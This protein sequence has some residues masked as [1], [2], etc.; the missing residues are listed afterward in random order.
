MSAGLDAKVLT[1]QDKMGYE[2]D[3]DLRWRD[4]DLRGHQ[5]K[6]RMATLKMTELEVVVVVR[7]AQAGRHQ[8]RQGGSYRSCRRRVRVLPRPAVHYQPLSTLIST[9]LTHW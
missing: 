7:T 3:L 2:L 5:V 4:V 9:R 8:L 6:T 1:R